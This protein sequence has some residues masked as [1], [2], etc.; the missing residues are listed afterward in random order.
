VAG[1][2]LRVRA[3]VDDAGLTIVGAIWSVAPAASVWRFDAGTYA[4][5]LG[6]AR[7]ASES[8][9]PVAALRHAYRGVRPST[10]RRSRAR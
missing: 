1:P 2:T 5:A 10:A 8:G 4:K 9:D 6:L 3:D 7:P